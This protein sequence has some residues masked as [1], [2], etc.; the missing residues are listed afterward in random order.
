MPPRLRLVGATFTLALSVGLQ[1]PPGAA[2]AAGADLGTREARDICDSL[3]LE[4]G[5]A[6]ACLTL[7]QYET[8]I[9]N[10]N[11][12]LTVYEL[13]VSSIELMPPDLMSAAAISDRRERRAELTKA[14]RLCSD[15][16]A[17]LAEVLLVMD[18][19]QRP[20][21]RELAREHDALAA[22][23]P[24]MPVEMADALEAVPIDRITSDQAALDDIIEDA[25]GSHEQSLEL[26]GLIA[27]QLDAIGPVLMWQLA[28]PRPEAVEIALSTGFDGVFDPRS[29]EQQ[30]YVTYTTEWA[31][32]PTEYEIIGSYRAPPDRLIAGT[33]EQ[34]SV[35]GE[36]V[37]VGSAPVRVY[38][39]YSGVGFP[40]EQ[41]ERC[42]DFGR[43]T[44]RFEPYDSESVP[45]T[46]PY[47]DHLGEE[48]LLSVNAGLL[49]KAEYRY[50]AVPDPDA[51]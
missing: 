33:V 43:P 38:L 45:F 10:V 6:D 21:L 28:E 27:D 42:A 44:E 16:A 41:D 15:R 37:G 7:L 20:R 40:P 35:T 3:Q 17:R 30:L 51:E 48:L 24:S 23:G 2:A 25:Q 1:S 34:L 36:V 5:A 11:A 46:V 13:V 47:P 22:L 12:E 9:D 14:Q 4:P 19:L 26:C 8:L 39:C 29:P 18:R 49:A 32:G 50:E 31:D